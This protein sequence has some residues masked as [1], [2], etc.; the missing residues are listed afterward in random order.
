MCY[1]VSDALPT[2]YTEE[3]NIPGTKIKAK[4]DYEITTDITTSFVVLIGIYFPSIT[5]LFC[6]QIYIREC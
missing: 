1:F 4:P 5:G 3:G 6:I 2:F